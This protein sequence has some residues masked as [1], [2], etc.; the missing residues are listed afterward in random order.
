MVKAELLPQ[1]KVSA[2]EKLQ[3]K[4]SIVAMVGD[5][6]NDAPKLARLSWLSVSIQWVSSAAL[7][8]LSFYYGRIYISLM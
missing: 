2:V 4:G 5:G 6:I 1:D 7:A 3:S 8:F